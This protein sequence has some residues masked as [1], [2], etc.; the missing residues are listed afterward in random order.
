MPPC[1]SENIRR[2]KRTST[3]V[4]SLR[5]W[6]QNFSRTA[7]AIPAH[8]LS[9]LYSKIDF[10][11]FESVLQCRIRTKSLFFQAVLHR[12]YLQ[13]ADTQ[14]IQ[15]NERLEFLGDSILNMV[16]AE[17]L[18]MLYPD[19][20]EGDLTI[21]RARLVNRKALVCYAKQIHLRDFLLL[22]DNACQTAEKGADTILADAYEAVIGAV[23]LDGGLNEA[24]RFVERQLTSALREGALQEADENYKSALLEYAQSK[25]M[26]SALHNYEGRG[27][28]KFGH[29]R[30][31]IYRRRKVRH[32]D[33]KEQERSRASRCAACTVPLGRT[34]IGGER[35]LSLLTN[36]FSFSDSIIAEMNNTIFQDDKF[37]TR[38]LGPGSED[39]NTMLRTIGVDSL[40]TL[41]DETIPGSIRMSAPLKLPPPVSEYRFL[42]EMRRIGAKNTVVKSMLGQG[43]YHCV[44]RPS[45]NGIFS[46]PGCHAVYSLP[47]GNIR[48]DKKLSSIIRQW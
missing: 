2:I 15:S 8:S 33:R 44:S 43:D 41:I 16:V 13:F 20:E 22:S 42:Q 7:P 36:L 32:R 38:H 6:V 45:S 21:M 30:R 35:T 34:A 17:R 46:I 29:F 47:A 23:Y 28:K 14:E 1:S 26:C 12:S 11:R 37:Q 5:R 4:S 24:K 10:K 3:G 48:G 25:G 39:L 31:G 40:D 27:A 19:A 9:E 18:Y